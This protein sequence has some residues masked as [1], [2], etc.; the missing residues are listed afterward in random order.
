MKLRIVLVGIAV[1]VALIVFGVG[2]V[3]GYNFDRE[4]SD[5]VKSK[6][7]L[8]SDGYDAIYREFAYFPRP[9]G[10]ILVGF[11]MCRPDNCAAW[12]LSTLYSVDQTPKQLCSF[13]EAEAEARG[14]TLV[15][16]TECDQP[17]DVRYHIT[18][19]LPLGD[20][21]VPIRVFVVPVAKPMDILPESFYGEARRLD[22]QIFSV[23]L[24]I[25]CGQTICQ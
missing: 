22:E 7:S 12:N 19:N 2:F 5:A 25:L 14:W 21:G 18:A 11:T 15:N 23:K 20:D 6:R 10:S 17:I 16:D 1:V 9:Y 24:Y 8:W 4:L 13:Y 3:I